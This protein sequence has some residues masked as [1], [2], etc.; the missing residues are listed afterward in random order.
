MYIEFDYDTGSVR[1]L[2]IP[3]ALE[4]RGLRYASQLFAWN[5]LG[6]CYLKNCIHW[7]NYAIGDLAE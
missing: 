4:A 1:T 3:E 2:S 6:T 5:R 7:E